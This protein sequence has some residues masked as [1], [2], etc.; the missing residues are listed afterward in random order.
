MRSAHV[1]VLSLIVLFVLAAYSALVTAVPHADRTL[2]ERMVSGQSSADL[3]DPPL[4]ETLAEGYAMSLAFV[5]GTNDVAF[6]VSGS[7][8]HDKALFKMDADPATGALDPLATVLSG[9]PIDTLVLRDVR[10]NE[11]TLRFAFLA[12]MAAGLSHF[13]NHDTDLYVMSRDTAT[14]ANLTAGSLDPL[15]FQMSPDGTRIVLVDEGGA[16]LSLDPSTGITVTLD[17]DVR[18]A[19]GQPAAKVAFSPDGSLLAVRT[20]PDYGY[21]QLRIYNLV[22]NQWDL[23]IDIPRANGAA[24][25]SAP[26]FSQD[27]SQVYFVLSTEG[28]AATPTGTA[29]QCDLY[30]VDLNLGTTPVVVANLTALTGQTG[31]RIT[32]LTRYPGSADLLFLHNERIYAYGPNTGK[33]TLLSS[34][35]EHVEAQPIVT[36]TNEGR[37]MAY[38]IR[39]AVDAATTKYFNRGGASLDHIRRVRLVALP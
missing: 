32:T 39:E 36:E 31:P 25:T 5:P 38:T 30:A 21:A 12:D 18:S 15:S 27:G 6:T 1:S 24:I 33:A 10:S 2:S 22:T 8:P 7:Y 17:A 28:A 4:D 20:A 16:L 11:P 3:E 35:S 14:I 29:F 34:A 13:P 37:W 9:M 23:T 26:L 19:A